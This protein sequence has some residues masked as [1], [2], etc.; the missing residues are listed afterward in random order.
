MT[1]LCAAMPPYRSQLIMPFALAFMG[2]F[3]LLLLQT[4]TAGSASA[5]PAEADPT[6]VMPCA[7]LNAHGA[8]RLLCALPA[9]FLILCLIG[10]WSQASVLERLYYT[11]TVRYEE[12][13]RLASA[14]E[15]RL[16]AVLAA[17]PEQLTMTRKEAL[18]E[19]SENAS[20]AAPAVV[21]IGS[22]HPALNN[23]CLQGEIIGSSFFE[24]DTNVAPVNYYSTKRILNFMHTLGYS[25]EQP[26]T[27][28]VEAATAYSA[29]MPVYPAD[30]SI[31]CCQDFI[32]VRLQ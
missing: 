20:S 7:A 32:I 4:L 2:S 29:D 28:Q 23:S 31:I 22:K 17:N 15:T 21:F 18:P 27:S 3:T 10:S 14:I 6:G 26:S 25:Y 9:A 11:N 30:G 24:W 13:V 12:D 16:E 1:I 8:S 19:N 5:D